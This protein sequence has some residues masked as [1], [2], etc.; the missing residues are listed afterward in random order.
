LGFTLIACNLEGLHSGDILVWTRKFYLVVEK[1]MAEKGMV[2]KGES[3]FKVNNAL[4]VKH[5]FFDVLVVKRSRCNQ[6]ILFC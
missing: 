5:D 6:D 4:Q 1:G 3:N 2:E